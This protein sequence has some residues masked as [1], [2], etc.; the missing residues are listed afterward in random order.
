M[1]VPGYNVDVLGWGGATVATVK[2]HIASL[3]FVGH[4]R[5]VLQIGS[6]DLCKFT[7]KEVPTAIL[8]LASDL[9]M[10]GIEKVVICELFYRGP[11]AVR[12]M[13]AYSSHSDYNRAVDRIN[14]L[15]RVRCDGKFFRF[16]KHTRSFMSQHLYD[17]DEVHIKFRSMKRFRQSINQALICL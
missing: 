4:K 14:Q 12:R 11:Q 3:N 5:V 8:D 2:Q 10:R 15:L 6:N 13:T 1:Y 7:V 9:I 16:W 17:L